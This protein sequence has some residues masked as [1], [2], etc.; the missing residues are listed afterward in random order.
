MIPV[1]Y[2]QLEFDT[3]NSLH[4]TKEIITPDPFLFC[5][6]HPDNN[7]KAP[8]WR[9]DEFP[10]RSRCLRTSSSPEVHS[11]P[12]KTQPRRLDSP[13]FPCQIPARSRILRFRLT[14]T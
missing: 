6:R 9:L 14:Q 12:W 10:V 8:L 4:G 1:C 2:E 3:I 7:T 5:S 11:P 13:R